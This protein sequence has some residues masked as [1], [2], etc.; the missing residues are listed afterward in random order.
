M[1]FCKAVC[2]LAGGFALGFFFFQVIP[3]VDG[4]YKHQGKDTQFNP[5]AHEPSPTLVRHPHTCTAN[6]QGINPGFKG[7]PQ[8]SKGFWG[9]LPGVYF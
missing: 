7:K 8:G 6:R 2:F 3:L 1:P 4:K 9:F 5:Y